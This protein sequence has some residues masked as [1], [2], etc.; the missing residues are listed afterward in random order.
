MN[1]IRGLGEAIDESMIVQKVLRSLPIIFDPKISSWEEIIDLDRL[2]MDERHG[3][4]TAYEMRIEKD[5]P[6]MKEETFKKSKKTK[7]QNKAKSKPN[8]SYN[9]DSEE[10]E[11]VVKFVRKLK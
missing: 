1:T 5:N 11:E 6:V 2:S 3:I 4:F 9:D 8:S 10:D 7:K